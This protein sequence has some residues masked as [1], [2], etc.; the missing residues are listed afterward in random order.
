ME[1]NVTATPPSWASWKGQSYDTKF[2]Y[3]GFGRIDTTSKRYQCFEPGTPFRLTERPFKSGVVSR[4]YSTELATITEYSKSPR[5]WKE[6]TPSGTQFFAELR[7][8]S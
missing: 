5:L 8:N 1:I 6:E 4:V 7:R 3:T 2:L